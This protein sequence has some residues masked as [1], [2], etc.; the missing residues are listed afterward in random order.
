MYKDIISYEL[1]EGV[2]LEELK[3]VAALVSKDWMQ[4]QAGFIKWE[5]TINQDGVYQDIVHWESKEAA[6]EAEKTMANMPHAAE[7][8]A[9][10]KPGSIS[11][12]NLTTLASF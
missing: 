12:K 7:W 2:S 6:K 8:F 11:S 3:K 5:I 4:K 9:C 10:Y 1:E